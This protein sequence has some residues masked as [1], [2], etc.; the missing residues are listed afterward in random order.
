MYEKNND[1]R[2]KWLPTYMADKKLTYSD[3][4]SSF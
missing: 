1:I 3:H 4:V 2:G